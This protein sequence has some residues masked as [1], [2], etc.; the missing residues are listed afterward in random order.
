MF[1][2]FPFSLLHFSSSQ[3]TSLAVCTV[4]GLTSTDSPPS[5]LQFEQRQH[6][7]SRSTLA[8]LSAFLPFIPT[9]SAVTSLSWSRLQAPIAAMAWQ[10]QGVEVG[11]T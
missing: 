4:R 7:F 3:A 6:S 11:F 10:W 8:T 5:R 1:D 2:T 9:L